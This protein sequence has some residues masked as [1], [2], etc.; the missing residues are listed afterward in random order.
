MQDRRKQIQNRI[1]SEFAQ[2]AKLAAMLKGTVSE[3][4]LGQRKRGRGQRITYLL[5]YKGKDN[6]TKSVYVPSDR[7][8]EVERM[9]ANHREARAILDTV[10]QL[11]VAL[12]KMRQ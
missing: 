12:F 8:A 5:T 2:I 4:R 1:D 10:A 6:R 11:N 3:V 9:I 7:R